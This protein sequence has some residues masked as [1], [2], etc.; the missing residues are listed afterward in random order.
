[1]NQTKSST[2]HSATMPAPTMP[3]IP[4]RVIAAHVISR[5]RQATVIGTVLQGRAQ[6]IRRRTERRQRILRFI[7]EIV[8]PLPDR[9]VQRLL[10]MPLDCFYS[11]CGILSTTINMPPDNEHLQLHTFIIL[12]W[13]AGGSYL[14]ISCI[15]G[16]SVSALYA[17]IDKQL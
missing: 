6:R 4:S 16:M 17:V 15:S 13:L 1:M 11:L 12:R 10:R 5:R 3:P 14:D 8:L 9:F 2:H 7:Q